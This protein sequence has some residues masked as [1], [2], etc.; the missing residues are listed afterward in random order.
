MWGDI[1]FLLAWQIFI[2]QQFY[3]NLFALQI[4]RI[5]LGQE[6]LLPVHVHWIYSCQHFQLPLS[7]QSGISLC[8][9]FLLSFP[10][11]FIEMTALV[12]KDVDHENTVSMFFT[13][14]SIN[15][16]P[17]AKSVTRLVFLIQTTKIFS[18]LPQQPIV[19]SHLINWVS[20]YISK[21]HCLFCY[22]NPVSP[23]I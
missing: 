18:S 5:S 8:S 19:C 13:C 20:E 12:L 14:C 7:R 23:L 3:Q 4:F 6:R 21:N 1:F 16:P 22:Y 2:L 10:K 11:C 15:F 17:C 9:F